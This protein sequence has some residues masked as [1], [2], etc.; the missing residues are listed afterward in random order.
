MPLAPRTYPTLVEGKVITFV[1]TGKDTTLPEWK[2]VLVNGDIRIT[3][4][5]EVC[6]ISFLLFVQPN[7]IISE[8]INGALYVIE[9]TIQDD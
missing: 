8:A 7:L 1:E 9:G 5:K 2:R 3:N 4:A 6:T